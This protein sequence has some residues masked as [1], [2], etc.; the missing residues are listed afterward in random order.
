MDFGEYI[1][2]A[3]AVGA[4][5]FVVVGYKGHRTKE[6]WIENAVTWVR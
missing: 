5:P 6:Q 1:A 3:K 4:E 2:T